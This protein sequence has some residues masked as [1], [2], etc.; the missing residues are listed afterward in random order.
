MSIQSTIDATA[1]TLSPSLARVAEF[2]RANPAAV[3]DN[4]INEL[5][6]LCNTSVASVV[7]FCRSIG[8]SGYAQ[9]RM[10]LASEM[11]KER[12]QFGDGMSFGSDITDADSLSD[13]VAKIRSREIL[14]IEETLAALDVDD[15]GR[16]ASL[17][18]ESDRILLY[19]VGAS[20]F[21]AADLGHK[22]LRIGRPA[23][24]LSDPHEAWACAA[25]PH[26][27]TVAI[28]FSH[29]GETPE[30]NRF[31]QI[32]RDAAGS[33]VG[34]TSVRDSTLGQ[35]VGIVL[36][37]QARETDFRAGAMVSRIAQLA[38]VDCL[39]TA[40]AQ[41]RYQQTLEALRVTRAATH[42]SGRP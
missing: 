24:V 30:T 12:A 39:F 7:R 22:L 40:I 1:G 32:A 14:A 35:N 42:G 38:L 10:A 3:V 2:I 16:A 6:G 17:I 37:T 4:T 15:L 18:S 23:V 25:L 28:A 20:Q 8:L 5:A 41:G 36:T 9:L 13:I 27:G 11:G 19:G 34:V 29:R 21:I 31:V 33:T 26:P